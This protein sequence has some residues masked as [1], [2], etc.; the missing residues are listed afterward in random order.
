MYLLY[1]LLKYKNYFSKKPMVDL[2]KYFMI[3]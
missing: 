3:L 2:K 1:N